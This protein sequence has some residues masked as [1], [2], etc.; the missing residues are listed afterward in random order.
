MA[1][2]LTLIEL[3]LAASEPSV[4]L[5]ENLFV[6]ALRRIGEQWADNVVSVAQEHR[7]SAITERILARIAVH[8]RGRPRGV[9][10][11]TTPP[12]EEH[13]LP[14][15]MAALALRADRWQVHH[16]GTQAPQDDLAQLALEEQTDLVVL[17]VA[18]PAAASAAEREAD[19]LR[20]L[21]H[22]VLVG[23]PGT[24]L[25]RVLADARGA[26]PPLDDDAP[27][28]PDQ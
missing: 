13:S 14:A 8:P 16:L 5:C 4:T 2:T 17:S 18:N 25:R 6:P 22:R 15:A 9:A 24:A 3:V 12:G 21:G 28:A 10:M 7:A 1:G 11:V 27:D 20:A 23:H 26:R 19:A